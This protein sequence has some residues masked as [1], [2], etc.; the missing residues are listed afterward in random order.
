MSDG[1]GANEGAGDTDRSN[2]WAARIAEILP[3]ETSASE[4]R[5]ERDTSGRDE[6]ESGS[7]STGR[8][9]ASATTFWEPERCRMSVVNSEMKDRCRVCLGDLS[10][11]DAMAP[12]RG[13]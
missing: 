1:E 9:R 13:L 4:G 3:T 8:D 12:Q 11:E 6:T 10:V 7:E 5:K 2:V